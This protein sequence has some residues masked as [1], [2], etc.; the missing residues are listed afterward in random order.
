MLHHIRPRRQAAQPYEGTALPK[1]GYANPLRQWNYGAGPAQHPRRRQ[2]QY[3]TLAASLLP[4]LIMRARLRRAGRAAV[5]AGGSAWVV[6]VWHRAPA[7]PTVLRLCPSALQRHARDLYRGTHAHYPPALRQKTD[8]ERLTTARRVPAQ[9]ARWEMLKHRRGYPPR[10]VAQRSRP[11]RAKDPA[12]DGDVQLACS[13]V[14]Y[15]T[16]T[17]ALGEILM[18]PAALRVRGR[19]R[20]RNDDEQ[21]GPARSAVLLNRTTRLEN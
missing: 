19:K 12:C 5:D 21:V 10:L 20:V 7:A 8:G 3:A 15:G 4:P 11:Q 13:K 2:R 16:P 6:V 14:D 1:Q 9:T 17:L 18:P